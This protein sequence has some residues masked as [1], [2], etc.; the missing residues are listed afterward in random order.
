MRSSEIAERCKRER[1]CC[2]SFDGIHYT[3]LSRRDLANFRAHPELMGAK[4]VDD[5]CMHDIIP[6]YRPIP[7]RNTPST[8]ENAHAAIVD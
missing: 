1:I 8:A 5:Y 7:L 4:L 6:G 3:P 2:I